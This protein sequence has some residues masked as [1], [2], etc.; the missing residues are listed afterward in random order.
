M[1]DV[2]R[3][4]K[5]SIFLSILLYLRPNKSPF[6][7]Y[8]PKSVPGNPDILIISTPKSHKI[9]VMTK[10]S[11]LTI[12]PIFAMENALVGQTF[13]LGYFSNLMQVDGHHVFSFYFVICKG[14]V[15]KYE[16][17]NQLQRGPFLAHSA[18]S[19]LCCGILQ[20]P[21]LRARP[22]SLV[23]CASDW[24]S[25]GHW[26]DPPVQQH[27][28]MEIGHETISTAILP[29]ADPSTAVVNYWRKYVH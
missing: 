2:V 20:I 1:L 17:I 24:Y 14:Y 13:D 21:P 11:F 23:G 22:G 25:G 16:K 7:Q 12:F 29:P 5:N 6:N 15:T 28:F 18:H 9:L 10:I 4:G 26:L 8:Y 27:F 19:P 3:N